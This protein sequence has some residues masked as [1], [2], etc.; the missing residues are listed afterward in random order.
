MLDS[1]RRVDLGRL[2]SIGWCGG[3]W[4]MNPGSCIRADGHA[5]MKSSVVVS[6]VLMSFAVLLLSGAVR[7][8]EFEPRTYAVAPVGLDFV[9]IGYTRC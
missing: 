7:A 8:R 6:R 9:S 4:M 2:R 3:S 1:H 5:R